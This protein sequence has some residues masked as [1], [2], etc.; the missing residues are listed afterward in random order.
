[1]NKNNKKRGRPRKIGYTSEIIEEELQQTLESTFMIE[2]EETIINNPLLDL[3][4]TLNEMALS[5]KKTRKIKPKELK[6]IRQNCERENYEKLIENGAELIPIDDENKTDEAWK[7]FKYLSERGEVTHKHYCELCF[8]KGSLVSYEKTTSITSLKG[9]LYNKHGID[10]KNPKMKAI[11]AI[12]EGKDVKNKKEELVLQLTIYFV[13][14]LTP[15]HHIQNEY[16]R[17]FLCFTGI[18]AD[19][20]EC[21]NE[22]SLSDNG[23]EKLYRYVHDEIKN[24]L[25][26]APKYITTLFDCWSDISRR[27]YF[28]I[29]LRFLNENFY[30]KE[31]VV[32]FKNLQY[33]DAVTEAETFTKV[34]NQFG[35]VDKKFIAVSDKGADMLCVCKILK[36]N[37]QD[38]VAHGLHNLVNADILPKTTVVNIFLKK[39]REVLSV[40]RYRSEDLILDLQLQQDKLKAE[41]LEKFSKIGKYI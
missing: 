30:V 26:S 32:A 39:L 8:K 17:A 14:T 18:I 5:V 16:T 38:C 10:V 12:M 37:R 21:P 13:M 36:I 9:H 19:P 4:K 40:L 15:F 22:R 6:S 23:L 31:Y 41:L 34:I 20:E 27:S 1:M 7:Y 2:H 35:L 25:Q 33:K 3:N 28:A 11:K 24:E 29:I